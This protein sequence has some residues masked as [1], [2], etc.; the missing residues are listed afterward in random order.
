MTKIKPDAVFDLVRPDEVAECW[1]GVGDLYSVL[2]GLVSEYTP[3]DRE[4]C[5]PADV[6]GINSVASFWDH[7]EPAQQKLLNQLAGSQG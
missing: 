3:I 4:D 7:L 1:E 5:G 6:I 2:W